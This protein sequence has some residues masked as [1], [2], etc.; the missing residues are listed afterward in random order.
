MAVLLTTILVLARS[1]HLMLQPNIFLQQ[2]L[3]QALTLLDV[4]E[5]LSSAAV[6][7]LAEIALHSPMED[8]HKYIIRIIKEKFK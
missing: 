1:F 5:P 4:V 2:L 8:T 7:V 3:I 6:L